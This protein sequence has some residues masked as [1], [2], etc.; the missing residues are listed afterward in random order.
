MRYGN[1]SFSYLPWR[2]SWFINESGDLDRDNEPFE[3]R[4][5]L[6]GFL[7]KIGKC[8]NDKLDISLENKSLL[9]TTSPFEV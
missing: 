9:I 6:I 3:Y 8:V 5:S 7:S 2:Y 1:Y 4:A